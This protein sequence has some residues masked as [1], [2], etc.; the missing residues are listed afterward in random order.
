MYCVTID[1]F[2]NGKCKRRTPTINA[3]VRD[4]GLSVKAV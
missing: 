3:S 1:M 2:F 4:E